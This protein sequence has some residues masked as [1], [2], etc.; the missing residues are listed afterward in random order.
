[1]KEIVR[2]DSRNMDVYIEYLQKHGLIPQKNPLRSA[3]DI[4]HKN[5]AGV[6]VNEIPAISDIN[7]TIK[8]R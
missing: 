3:T 1:M 5:V 4:Q 7:I 8:E 6:N 2:S